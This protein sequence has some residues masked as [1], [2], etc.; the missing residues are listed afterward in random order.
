MFIH[1]LN[2]VSIFMIITLNSLSGRLLISSSFSPFSEVLS[3]SFVSLYFMCYFGW[4]CFLILENW[5][6]GGGSLCGPAA[7][8]PLIQNSM[9]YECTLLKWQGQTGCAD[10]Q[11]QQL[12]WPVR[13]ASS[14]LSSEAYLV[15]WLWAS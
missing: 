10:R 15:H 8:S 5:P 14:L 9:C 7:H 1:S 3:C 13:L 12:N 4:S 11:H 6:Y 2:L